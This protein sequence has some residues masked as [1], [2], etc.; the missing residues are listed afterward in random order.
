[1]RLQLARTAA[2]I[3][4]EE[5]VRDYEQAKHKAC[6]RSDVDTRNK[7]IL[8]S[9]LEIQQAL[10]DYLLAFKSDSQPFLIKQLREAALDVMRWL[11]A[12]HPRLV[13]SVLN[14]TADPYA[15]VH[16]HVFA[17]TVEEV[18]FFLGDRGINC[19]IRTRSVQNYK[20]VREDQ[21]VCMFNAGDT[22]I[23]LTL[24]TVDD[25]RQ[26]PASPV[27]GKPMKRADI[28]TVEQLI[29]DEQNFI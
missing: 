25:L 29:A 18:L 11:I 7:A 23:E 5:A 19:T 3:M 14:G 13:G 22:P 21:T 28:K 20:G 26:A 1:M 8:P 2:Q 27:D 9:N 10:Y 16:L 12:F 15:A 17:E 24:F 6:E 4:Y